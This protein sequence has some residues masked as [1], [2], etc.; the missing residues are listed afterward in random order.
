LAIAGEPRVLL[1]DEPTTA[2]D[3]TIQDQILD[4]LS[5][6]QEETGMAIVIVSH[7]LGVIAQVCDDVA[8]MYAGHI[9]ESGSRNAVIGHARHP[10]TQALLAAAPSADPAKRRTRL[11]SI[12][13]QPPDI[14]RSI[15][16][17]PFQPRCSHVSSSCADIAVEVDREPPEHGSACPFVGSMK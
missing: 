1:A 10:Y 2:L 14:G 17:C 8:V 7:D 6:V 13:G 16:G 4:L 5:R 15:P 11:E 12:P 9:L 3:V